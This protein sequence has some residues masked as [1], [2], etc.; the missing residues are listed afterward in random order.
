[1]AIQGHTGSVKVGNNVMGNAKAWSLDISQETAD[2][3]DFSSSGWK[4]STT[5]LKSW[6]GSL[7]AIFDATGSA[8][9]SLVGALTGGTTLDLELNAGDTTDSESYD[10]Y[11][12]SAN[13]TSMSI[14]NDVNGIVEASFN[15]EG[16]GAITIA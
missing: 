10:K 1:M 12:G 5:T 7:T 16:T 13:I 15:F 14:T 11:S 6:S 4:E 8:E 3:T 9:G 2:I